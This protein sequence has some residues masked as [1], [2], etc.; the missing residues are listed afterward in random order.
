MYRKKNLTQIFLARGAHP[1]TEQIVK[2]TDP[3]MACEEQSWLLVFN[4]IS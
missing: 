4:L 2:N 1:L 3:H